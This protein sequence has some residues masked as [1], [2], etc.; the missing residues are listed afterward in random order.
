MRTLD[1]KIASNQ[2]T[3]ERGLDCISLYPDSAGAWLYRPLIISCADRIERLEKR[4]L[5]GEV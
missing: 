3:I 5:A 2:E 1:Q 4:K